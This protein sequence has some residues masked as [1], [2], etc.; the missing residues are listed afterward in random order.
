MQNKGFTLIELLVV[1]AVFMFIIGTAVTIFVSMA[2]YQRRLLSEQELL[3]Q[4][5]YMVEHMSK[6]LM[7]AKKDDGSCL[8]SDYIGYSYVLTKADKESGKYLGIKFMNQNTDSC[9]EIYLDNSDP[10]NKVIKEKIKN[11]DAMALTSTKF[12]INYL[13]FI[14][15]GKNDPKD[16]GL[17]G[18]SE[19]DG[20]QPRVTIVL[21]IQSKEIQNKPAL[22]IQTTVSQRNLNESSIGS[23]FP[24]SPVIFALA[25]PDS[26]PEGQKIDISAQITDPDGVNSE[27]VSCTIKNPDEK[28]MAGSPVKLK[29]NGGDNYSGTWTGPA[30][31]YFATVHACDVLGNCATKDVA[32]P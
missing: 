23:T 20:V 28:E 12:K 22:K 16:P 25:V 29:S 32:P 6:A 27:T 11:N 18:A 21:D 17:I 2:Q 1:T 10:E 9:T 13:N 8:G 7:M 5:S 26:A 3:N 31:A 24:L 14:I 4:A 15:N 19:K 30:G